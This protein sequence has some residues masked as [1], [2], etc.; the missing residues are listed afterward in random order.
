VKVGVELVLVLEVT[1]EEV[2][3]G[4]AEDVERGTEMA[5]VLAQ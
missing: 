4:G 3:D 5:L 2:G 1:G